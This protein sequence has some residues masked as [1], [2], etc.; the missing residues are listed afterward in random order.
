[1]L[2]VLKPFK[3]RYQNNKVFKVNDEYNSVNKEHTEKLIEEKY[4]KEVP[5]KNINKKQVVQNE[6]ADKK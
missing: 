2:K 3:C 4:I 6:K 5:S 1:M